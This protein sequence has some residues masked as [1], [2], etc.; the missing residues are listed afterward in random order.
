MM[1]A[2]LADRESVATMAMKNM[3]IDLD[4]MAKDVEAQLGGAPHLSPQT[5]LMVP[6]TPRAKKILEMALIE[7]RS[8]S[9]KYA[10]TEHL[11]LALIKDT[12]SAIEPIFSALSRP[13]S[14]AP[15]SLPI[16]NMIRT[17]V[18]RILKGRDTEKASNEADDL[19][20][21]LLNLV[22]GAM[23]LAWCTGRYDDDAQQ[24]EKA[25]FGLVRRVMEYQ[26]RN[27]EA[28]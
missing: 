21:E 13:E 28:G 20:E 8:M 25:A 2:L 11:L 22:C 1:L 12:G 9:H 4:K 17:Q 5:G 16:Y 14:V 23:P 3:G 10:G 19:M 27:G 15:G 24:W 18:E 6:F 26:K 7:A